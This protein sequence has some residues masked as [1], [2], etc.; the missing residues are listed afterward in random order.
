MKNDIE[1][2]REIR[3]KVFKGNPHK[4]LGLMRES[5]WAIAVLTDLVEGDKEKARNLLNEA[6]LYNNEV[7]NYL[8]QEDK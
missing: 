5:I 2:G 3:D 6:L 1:I 7:E 8:N 4:Q